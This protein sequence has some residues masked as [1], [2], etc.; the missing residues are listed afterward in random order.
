[1][2]AHGDFEGLLEEPDESAGEVFSSVGAIRGE[3]ADETDIAHLRLVVLRDECLG[4]AFGV[5][6]NS[7]NLPRPT[8]RLARYPIDHI[9]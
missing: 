8:I 5:A 1:L 3:V 4:Q 7:A 2:S 9:N 6:V